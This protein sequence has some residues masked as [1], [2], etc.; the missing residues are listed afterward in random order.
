MMTALHWCPGR[1]LPLDQT[2][3]D[4]V[5][6]ILLCCSSICFCRL[7]CS[8]GCVRTGFIPDAPHPH[9]SKIPNQPLLCMP[10]ELGVSIAGSWLVFLNST[11]TRIQSLNLT[12]S[13]LANWWKTETLN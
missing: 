13:T 12:K 6:V 11:L 10:D 8:P 1:P 7:L 9:L 4:F 3:V 2:T 5:S